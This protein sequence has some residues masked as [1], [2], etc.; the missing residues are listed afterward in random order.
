[1]ERTGAWRI[2]DQNLTTE[3][4]PVLNKG[5]REQYS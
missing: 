5:E 3:L 4:D 2:T 1:M